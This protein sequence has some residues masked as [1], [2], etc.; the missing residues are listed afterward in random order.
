MAVYW[1]KTQRWHST[2]SRLKGGTLLDQDSK[3][4][5]YWIKSQRWHSTGSSLKGGTLLDQ[6]PK[7]ALYWIK[8]QRWHST[9]SRLKGGTLL[10]QDSK[11]AL[12]WI[13]TQRWH[14]TGSR[15]KG[16][17]L[18]D[19]RMGKRMSAI[20]AELGQ[21]D[22]QFYYCSSVATLCRYREPSRY[23]FLRDVTMSALILITQATWPTLVIWAEWFPQL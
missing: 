3:V 13:K 19:Q 9:G 14:S 18:L 15:L 17:T 8:S 11:V 21:P 22:M 5:L 16:G 2:G 20:C 1:I 4:A 10:D 7:V 6:D 23:S 12:Y